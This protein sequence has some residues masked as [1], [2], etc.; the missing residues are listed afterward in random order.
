[1]TTPGIVVTGASGRMGQ[2]LI[3]TIAA[4]DKARLVGA[5]ERRGNPWIGR[6]VGEAMG[7]P[8]TGVV[9]TDDPLEAFAKAQA[10]I[11]F[12]APAATVEFA[13]LAA[14]ARAVHVIGTTGLEAEHLKKIA[15]A[16]HHAVIVRAGNMSLGVN[17]LTR[18]TQKVAEALDSDWDIE[19]VEA[20]HRMKVDAPSGTALMLGEA[21][22]AGR[23]VKLADVRDSGRDGITGARK[24]GNIG[25]AAI[26]GGDVVGEHDVI[27]ATAGERIVLRHIATDRAIFARGALKAALWGQG[28]KPGEYDMMDVLGL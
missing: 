17:L 19:I 10:V 9:V 4:S 28:Q 14:Q 18:L 3:R 20:H 8:A 2:M 21:A 27:F 24:P 22:A 13:A 7:G 16:A 23:G 5:V 11:D 1:M 12:T 15:L 26:R 25:F 6:D